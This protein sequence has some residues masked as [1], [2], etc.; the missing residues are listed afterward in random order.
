MGLDISH[1][2]L[3]LTPNDVRDFFT[4][5]TWDIDCNLPIDVYSKYLTDIKDI[6]FGRIIA[7]V[8]NEYELEVLS[9]TEW[10][11]AAEYYKIFIGELNTNVRNDLERF[12]KIE[13]LDKLERLEL[14]NEHDG[15]EYHTI[16][17][18]EDIIKKGFYYNDIGYQR[19]RMND[20][21]YELFKD[22]PWLL[23]KKEDFDLAYSCVG[24][25]WYIENWGQEAVDKMRE[26]FKRDF[27][28]KFEYGKSLLTLSF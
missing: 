3:T 21:F 2:Q 5:E 4:V 16:S 28:D 8:K 27:I 18:G 7:I 1:C 20:L 11:N 26:D 19:K 23:G 17:F 6:D 14:K 9:K 25:D 12:I 22:G 24:G 10:F 15:V 13:N